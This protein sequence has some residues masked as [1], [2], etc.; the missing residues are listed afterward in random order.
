MR[1]QKHLFEDVMHCS[2]HITTWEQQKQ[3]SVGEN[4]LTMKILR[5]WFSIDY[6]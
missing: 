4:V 2:I 5:E 6:N 1:S 3:L